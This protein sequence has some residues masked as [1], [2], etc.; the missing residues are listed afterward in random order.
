MICKLC[1]N[2]FIKNHFN[3]KLCS[4]LCKTNSR[5]I[6][7]ARYKKTESGK[8]TEKRWRKNPIKKKIDK[9]YY[10]SEKGRK[11]AVE[12]QIRL[13]KQ[14]YYINLKRMRQNAPYRKLKKQLIEKY[15]KCVKCKS[16]KNL[17]IDH[18][19]PMRLGG[20]HEI[21]NIQIL[22]NSCNASKGQKEIR[23]EL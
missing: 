10:T 5:K 20:K 12:R 3:Q 2:S 15:K 1:N 23:Y 13:L 17:T 18:I 8:Q 6:S 14:E 19:K 7:Q 11:K 16:E 21:K 4:E 22:C 9:K